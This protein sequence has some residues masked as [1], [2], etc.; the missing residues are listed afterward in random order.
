MIQTDE[1]LAELAK[2]VAARTIELTVILNDEIN[3]HLRTSSGSAANPGIKNHIWLETAFLGCYV[4]QKKFTAGMTDEERDKFMA[5]FRNEF[6]STV[7]S[8][9]FKLEAI[10]EE[11]TRLMLEGDYDDK[12]KK[13]DAYQGPT[14]LLFKNELQRSLA[15]NPE[16]SKINESFLKNKIMSKAGSLFGISG[17]SDINSPLPEKT[18]IA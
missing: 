10:E 6:M 2:K 15:I 3:T 4:L 17:K 8:K 9:T 14:A 12:L 7:L 13:Y 11:G 18:L 5:L 16:K 1:Q